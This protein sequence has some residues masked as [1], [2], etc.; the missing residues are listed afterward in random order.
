MQVIIVKKASEGAI[1][2]ANIIK[3]EMLK[4]KNIVLGLATGRTPIS[5]YE[6]LARMHKEEGLDFSD[7]TSFNLDEYCNVDFEKEGSYHFF[8]NKHLFSKVNIKKENTNVP[9]ANALDLEKECKA[10]EDK[11]KSKGGIDIQL[12]GIGQDGHIGFNEPSCSL[13]SRTRKEF[14]TLDTREAN[15]DDYGSLDKMPI[16]AVTMGIGTIMEAKKI[17]LLAFGK[18]KRRAIKECVEGGVS[19]LWPASIL[20]FHN[21]AT[22]IV[23]EEAAADLYN[24][25]YYKQ[26]YEENL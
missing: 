24:I 3:N 16:S 4:K 11:I 21:D 10:Y 2:G 8:M 5:L 20:Q 17:L 22:I 13:S 1:L 18:S 7:V 14:L 12:L 25:N 26:K 23:D 19:S 9:N 6:E 15:I